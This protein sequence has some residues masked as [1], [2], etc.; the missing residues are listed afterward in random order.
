MGGP[1]TDGASQVTSRPNRERWHT[2]RDG[3]ETATP[4]KRN[5]EKKAKNRP[6][7]QKKQKK[8]WACNFTPEEGLKTI[9]QKDRRKQIGGAKGRKNQSILL[10][11]LPEEAN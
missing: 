11:W 5:P 2:K 3:E 10:G 8:S 9:L 7:F 1:I 4:K 6:L